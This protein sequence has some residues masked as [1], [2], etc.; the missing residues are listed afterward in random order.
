MRERDL[1]RVVFREPRQIV[2]LLAGG[3]RRKSERES[4]ERGGGS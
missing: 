3:G 4:R 1:D 2:R